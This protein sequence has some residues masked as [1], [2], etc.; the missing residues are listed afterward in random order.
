MELQTAVEQLKT[1]QAKMH[2]YYHAME[3]IFYDSVT[4]APPET[5]VGRGHTMGILSEERHKLFANEQ[6]GELLA[7]L[8]SH[9]GEL[10]KQ[11]AREIEELQR[12]HAMLSRVPVEEYVAYTRLLNEADNK[13]LKAKNAS[14]F[15]IFQPC[16]EKIVAFS[17][18]LAGYYAPEKKPYDALLDQ[19]ERGATMESLDQ[20]FSQLKAELIPLLERI[21]AAPQ[22]DN[23]LLQRPS[24]IERQKQLTQYLMDIMSLDRRY[25]AV[26]ETEHP[27]TVEFN[28]YDVRITTHYYEDNLFSSLFSVIHEG[29]HAL[30][31][32]N[33]ADEL[34]YTCLGEGASSAIHESQSRFYE[35]IIAR[36]EPFLRFLLPKL[37]ELFPENY[38]NV[39][40]ENLYRAVVSV[41]PSLTRIE[42]DEIT[43]PLH[44][45]VRY[46]LEK[47][48]IG[49]SLSVADLPGEWNRLYQE[50][51]GVEVPDDRRG[52]LQ[53]VHWA[54]GSFGYF[55]T[56]ALG[57][58]YGAQFL[59]AMQ[60]DID[61]WGATAK[62][63][64]QPVTAWLKEKIHRHGRM[65]LPAD[66]I[67]HATG[68]PFDP[69]YYIEYL[70][71]KYAAVYQL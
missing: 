5:D 20:F 6:V 2:A 51:L 12:D 42:A 10:D 59:A 22:I 14:D 50:Y 27:F 30:Y 34:M 25:A 64:L 40:A 62:G 54:G 13:W 9:K 1:L 33:T 55:P 67:V 7:Y 60:R 48:L 57:S 44:I 32:L 71:E 16:L 41:R 31:E 15:A 68:E 19:Y 39:D 43:Y 24:P 11:T 18:K 63:D 4:A 53:D 70:K 3:L 52:V 49:G 37:C 45:L 56:Y 8:A 28:K 21:E 35:N 17:R 23:S 36:S 29:G 26:G 69:R 66:L 46:E 65:Q 47:R 58:A 61:V 38:A